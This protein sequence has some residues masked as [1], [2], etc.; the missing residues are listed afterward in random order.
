MSTCQVHLVSVSDMFKPD[1]DYDYYINP[2]KVRKSSYVE[3]ALPTGWVK[4]PGIE[5]FST[6]YRIKDSLFSTT[7]SF[8]F[9]CDAAPSGGTSTT[10]MST[11]LTFMFENAV[12][13]T[14]YGTM[15]DMV[16]KLTKVTAVSRSTKRRYIS[17]ARLNNSGLF[18]QAYLCV[19]P[20]DTFHTEEIDGIMY[21]DKVYDNSHTDPCIVSVRAEAT[22]S[23]QDK[24]GNVVTSGEFAYPF[25]DIDY[26]QVGE[27]H[28]NPYCES[29]TIVDNCSHVYAHE[30]TW[31][32]TDQ[33]PLVES[34]GRQLPLRVYNGTDN[35]EDSTVPETRGLSGI[36]TLLAAKGTPFIWTGTTCH[37]SLTGEGLETYSVV[38]DTCGGVNGPETQHKLE[39][40]S[41]K[42]SEQVPQKFIQVTCDGNGGQFHPDNSNTYVKTIELPFLGWA[43]SSGGSV[44]YQP[45]DTLPRNLN[46]NVT[47]Y[48]VWDPMPIGN[49][50]VV[51]SQSHQ[52]VSRDTYR[53]DRDTPWTTTQNGSTG[54]TSTTMVSSSTTIYAKW[55]YRIRL[56]ANGGQFPADDQ[57]SP[58]SMFISSPIVGW[59]QHGVNYNIYHRATRIGHVVKGWTTTASGTVKYYDDTSESVYSANTP[60]DLYILWAP[61]TFT[62]TFK[63]GYGSNIV[64]SQVTN[65]PYGTDIPESAVPKYG[66]TYMSNGRLFKRSGP[67]GFTGWSRST[68][69]V[70]SNII[71]EATWEFSPVWIVIESN[72]AK[73]WVP[74]KPKEE[75]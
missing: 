39:R 74:Y 41:L 46:Q 48:A 16:V 19:R 35:I 75:G 26:T 45:G 69:N 23:I 32:S 43:T 36:V 1:I 34:S 67:Y 52:L 54:V 56:Y 60:I 47:L 68:K 7:D 49:L 2:A 62:A 29:I 63:T 44:T 22:L 5:F 10:V 14:S 12:Q 37:S 25:L 6:N 21:E 31:L 55:E 72:G 24:Q 8:G 4:Q 18:L 61:A 40:K 27:P 70:R 73:F 59:K 20:D 28:G 42:L 38:Y 51:G 3:T 57:T 50:P 30:N 64:I 11:A 13:H 53:L 33:G 58:D 17:I 15:F 9:E 71:L 66:Q 65:I